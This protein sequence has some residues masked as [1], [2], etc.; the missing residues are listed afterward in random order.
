MIAPTRLGGTAR[1]M[2]CC[3]QNCL[4][5]SRLQLPESL[6][7]D[8]LAMRYAEKTPSNARKCLTHVRGRSSST[9]RAEETMHE[10]QPQLRKAIGHG[11]R[12]Q[13]GTV[14][15]IERKPAHPWHSPSFIQSSCI[16]EEA[17]NPESATNLYDI[18]QSESLQRSP[19]KIS[20]TSPM[21]TSP[22][23]AVVRVGAHHVHMHK[24][25][26]NASPSYS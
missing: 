19:S 3:G 20:R 21:V 1:V 23:L 24:P 15:E 12:H 11:G 25:P 17:S 14:G 18:D 6:E 4:W 7:P 16:L 26:N 10:L 2:G 8:E 13:I 5:L 22:R 9:G